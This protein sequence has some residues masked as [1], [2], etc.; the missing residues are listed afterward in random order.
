MLDVPAQATDAEFA[1]RFC[2]GEEVARP[3]GRLDF[4]GRLPGG[5]PMLPVNGRVIGG[6]HPAQC[7]A[8]QV[9]GTVGFGG[10]VHGRIVARGGCLVRGRIARLGAL[11]L[12]QYAG[13]MQAR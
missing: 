13:N 2:T 7:S 6:D 9:G 11:L 10:E 5:E 12:C 8:I 4:A 3:G 1:R